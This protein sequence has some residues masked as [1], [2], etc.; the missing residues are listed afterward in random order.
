[1]KLESWAQNWI[2][3]AIAYTFFVPPSRSFVTVMVHVSTTFL[4]EGSLTKWYEVVRS[5]EVLVIRGD[6]AFCTLSLRAMKLKRIMV[7]MSSISL[8]R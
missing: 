6:D 1:M 8:T 3:S 7:S 4:S 2:E 5:K